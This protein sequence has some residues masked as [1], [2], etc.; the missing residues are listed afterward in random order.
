MATWWYPQSRDR[1]GLGWS[2][3]AHHYSTNLDLFLWLSTLGNR[4]PM[5]TTNDLN[6]GSRQ[7]HHSLGAVLKS[8]ACA[9]LSSEWLL[10]YPLYSFF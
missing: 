4:S 7:R 1:I 5:L 8:L 6:R 9:L 2:S 10:T 3:N